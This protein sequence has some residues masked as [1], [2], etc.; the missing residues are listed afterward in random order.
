[1]RTKKSELRTNIYKKTGTSY[2][3]K[4]K[5]ARAT[6]SDIS[7]KFG[8]F[9]FTIRSC[10]DERQTRMGLIECTKMG[11]VQAFD[12]QEEKSSEAVAQVTFTALVTP[13]GVERI[14]QG[15]VFD[16]KVIQT[17]KKI[18]DAEIRQLLETST[19]IKKKPVAATGTAKST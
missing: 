5:S 19:K 16:S 17:D 2:Q 9:P 7:S 13:N 1:G 18:E 3:L 12:I 4:M 14:T 15:L 8:T 11:V 6:F 10:E